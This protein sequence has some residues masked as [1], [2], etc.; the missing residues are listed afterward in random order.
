MK[1]ITTIE[2]KE[3]QVH[4]QMEYFQPNVHSDGDCFIRAICKAT[5][6]DWKK[7]YTFAFIST[8][9][10]QYMP[11]GKEGVKIVCKKLGYIWHSHN[12]RKHRPSVLEFTGSHPGGTY[13][14][15]LSG[16]AVCVENGSYYDSWDCGNRKIY[17]YW[18]KPCSGKNND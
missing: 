7:A 2:G 12:S 15:K 18:E 3:R 11:N 6:W 8:I 10:D 14:M 5:G 1:T 13:I 4:D 17:G 16:H 9:K